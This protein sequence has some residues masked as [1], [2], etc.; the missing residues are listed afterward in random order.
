MI[1]R[2]ALAAGATVQARY[3]EPDR[4]GCAR[5][6]CARRSVTEFAI[7][8]ETF[9]ATSNM[10][11]GE[12]RWPSGSRYDIEGRIDGD[13]IAFRETGMRENP[14]NRAPEYVLTQNTM[15]GLDD[16]PKSMKAWEIVV[17]GRA[18]RGHL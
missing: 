17:F 13:T 18:K 1:L 12:A 3:D 8:L 7:A 11:V 6:P 16:L 14:S 10:F 15:A 2:D 4:A 9:D 5:L